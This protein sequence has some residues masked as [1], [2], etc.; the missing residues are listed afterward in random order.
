[1]KELALVHSVGGVDGGLTGGVDCGSREQVEPLVDGGTE[2][3]V[4]YNGIV[5]CCQ[6]R[7]GGGE[8]RVCGIFNILEVGRNL[9]LT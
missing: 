7:C 1:M 3:L 9:L 6:A 8:A 2:A 4:R 5:D